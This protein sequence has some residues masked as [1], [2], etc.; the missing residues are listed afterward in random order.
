MRAIH[1]LTGLCLASCLVPSSQAFAAAK[2]DLALTQRHK[3][4]IHVQPLSSA[5]RQLSTQSGV[6]ILFPYDEVA[7][8]RSRRIQGWLSTQE[9]LGRLLAGT[10]LKMEQAG[11]GVIALAAPAN[12][13]AARRSPLSL[14]FAQAGTAGSVAPSRLRNRKKQRK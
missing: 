7:A 12:R 8:I 9:A 13:S 14:Q 5:L 4:D 6:R 10:D 3:F 2:Q 1:A 11:A